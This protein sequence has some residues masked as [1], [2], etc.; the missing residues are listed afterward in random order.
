MIHPTRVKTILLAQRALSEKTIDDFIA[1]AQRKDTNLLTYLIDQKVIGE[2]ELYDMLAQSYGVQFIDLHTFTLTDDLRTLLPETIVQTH[3]V[4]VFQRDDAAHVLK[5]ATTDPDDLQT[6]DFIRKKT[7]Y[8]VQVFLTNPPSIA[9]VARQYHSH[10]EQEFASFQQPL[11][12]GGQLS[13]TDIARNI[14]IIKMLDTVLDYAVFQNASDVHIEPTD[15]Q[16]IIRF[17]IDGVLRDVMTLPKSIQAGLTAR[18]KVLS[19]LKLDEHRLPQDGRITVETQ[20]G[21]IALRVSILPVY[22][23][24]KV[25]MRI[26][27]ESK[28]ILTLEQLG[29]NELALPIIKNHVVKPHG[30]ILASGPTGSGKTT[31]LYTILNILNTPEVNISTVEDP[32]EYRMIRV[33]QSQINPKIGFSFASGLRALLRQDPNII[34]VGEIRDHET[35]EIAAHAA[36]T[37]HLVL[38]TIHTNDAVSTVFRLSEMDVPSFLIASTVNLVIAQ[39]LVRKICPHC[40]QSY[41]LTDAQ[42]EDISKQYALDQV[43]AGFSKLKE[44]LS[45]VKTLKDIT[46]FRGAGCARCF[47]TGY[48]GRVGIYEIFEMTPAAS[49]LILQRQSKTD[50][51]TQAT[52]D[53]MITMVQDAFVKAKRGLTTIEE[54]LRVTKE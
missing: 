15:Q 42:L 14:P 50:L 22:D 29:F 9:N 18:I 21:N 13:A 52:K 46:F 7:G 40:V 3:E 47:D 4:V 8:A 38:S 23:G 49:Q 31:T 34:M 12:Q 10:I 37:G 36:M 32:I 30:M 41:T 54:I 24:E 19:N 43:M 26:L 33:N 51:F 44:D 11:E 20:Q 53:G 25:V 2:Q 5:I 17:R 27:D 6:I 1:K 39:R 35:A 48:K 45:E 16:V 28:N